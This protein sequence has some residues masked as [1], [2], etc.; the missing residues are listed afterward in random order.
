LDRV[1]DGE[2]LRKD[3]KNA[4]VKIIPQEK[5]KKVISLEDNQNAE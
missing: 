1:L 5:G 2:G 4:K 3:F